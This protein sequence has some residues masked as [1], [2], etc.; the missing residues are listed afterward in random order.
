MS[1]LGLFCLQE[2]H[3]PASP[4]HAF[5]LMHTRMHLH[6]QSHH[7]PHART[8][9]PTRTHTHP[10]GHTLVHSCSQPT[11]I[12]QP[13]LLHLYSHTWTPTR[14]HTYA[15][16]LSHIHAY[17]L[18]RSHIHTP[19]H[20]CGL[21]CHLTLP[22]FTYLHSPLQTCTLVH[23]QSGT[24][25]HSRTHTHTCTH[26]HSH[27]HSLAHQE[28]PAPQQRAEAGPGGRE[29]TTGRPPRF[30]FRR[31]SPRGSHPLSL[32]LPP[33]SP[34][35][36]VLRAPPLAPVPEP[37]EPAHPFQP[38]PPPSSTRTLPTQLAFASLSPSR[39]TF[40]LT[41]T[42]PLSPPSWAKYK[43]SPADGSSLFP[44]LP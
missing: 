3:H 1:S 29:G 20:S 26:M 27:A 32:Q 18:T 17:I 6:S 36:N 35:G 40:P 12:P 22:Q 21:T 8:H 5:T 23:S 15:L 33:C 19:M 31:P 41:S 4:P 9:T 11:H 16:T 28:P 7:S 14:V 13:T 2:T 39:N 43:N 25:T 44:E 24:L 37:S 42:S 34:R 30:L 38:A 10:H